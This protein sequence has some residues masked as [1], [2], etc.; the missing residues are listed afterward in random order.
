MQSPR[1]IIPLLL[2]LVLLG[3]WATSAFAQQ[4]E[5]DAK[6]VPAVQEPAA[7]TPYSDVR[8]DSLLNGLQLITLERASEPRVICDLVIRSGAMFDLVSKAGL[9][10]LTQEALLI[11]NPQLNDELAS[12]QAKMGWGVTP[13]TTW[14]HIEAPPSNFD[15]V[16]QIIGRLLVIEAVRPE[17]FKLAQQARLERVKGRGRQ[18]SPAER[19]DEAFF[20][21]LYGDH[22][23]GHNT[24]G[25]EKTIA[26]IVYGDVYDFY[27][28]FYLANNSF[29]L[30]VSNLKQ[31][32][33]LRTFKTFLGGWMKGNV[34]PTSFRQM[35]RT[36][37]GQP[38][39]VEAP[40]ASAVELRGGVIGV[41]HTDPDFL[42]TEVLA[43][44]LE[45][46]LK[47]NAAGQAGETLIVTAP[48][49]MLPGPL[50]ISASLGAEQAAEFSRR[51]TEAFTALANAPVTAE[52]LAA[53]KASLSAEDAARTIPD[54]LREV[55]IYGLPRNYPLT[56]ATRVNAVS[57]A[58]VQRVAK[59][60]L[61]GNA[62]TIVM[63]GR[64]GEHFKSQ[65]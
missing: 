5:R 56:F 22:P 48:P 30:V 44:V 9:A 34:V 43:R 14:F 52:E 32:R 54:H 60:L 46:R 27:K 31:E 45:A 23:Y 12:L 2:C 7:T 37:A 62:L 6:K 64:V 18:L 59:R 50:F 47:R 49:R 51:A 25:N 38:L 26:A 16:M 61:E 3:G 8:R 58:D 13:D 28:R 41:K 17:S 35:Q 1:P 42:V 33:V 29:A 21:A 15:T 24:E 55:E 40:E 11:V 53:A 65:I 57:A 39:K 19:A 4:K 20:A 63:L 36:A 10:A